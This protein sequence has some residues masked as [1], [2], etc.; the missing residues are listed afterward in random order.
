MSTNQTAPLNRRHTSPAPEEEGAIPDDLPK[1]KTWGVLIAAVV[2]IA[3]FVGLFLVG[4]IPRTARLAELKKESTEMNDMR[5]QVQVARP[6]RSPATISVTLPADTAAWQQTAIFPQANGYLEKQ[7]VD[8]G[9]VV[10][11]GQLLAVISSPDVD[12]QLAQAK[13]NVAQS[14]AN[15]TRTQDNEQLARATLNR[16]EGFFKTGGITQ[17]QLDQFRSA[18]T[19]AQS[20][21]AGAKASVLAA[22]ANVERLSSL[23]AFEKVTAPFAGTITSRNYNLGA[24]M[25]A[26]NTSPGKELFDIANTSVLRVFVDV[27]QM[28]VTSA[29]VGDSAAVE[30][31]NYPGR[32]FAGTITRTSGSVDPSTRKMRYEIDVPNK[33]GLLYPGMYAQAVLKI[34]MSDRSILIPTGALVFDAEGTKVW[35]EQNGVIHARKVTVGRNLGTGIEITRGLSGDENIVTNPGEQLADGAKVDVIATQGAASTS[36]QPLTQP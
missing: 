15:L 24:L 1:V 20:D 12:A 31:R 6:Q 13:A 11:S 22:D 3:A 26:T 23:Q 35:V 16:Y 7:L 34:H 2:V 4:W 33:D 29:K 10:K 32:D 14:H 25:S 18:L 9:D 19:A 36:Q 28:Y 30:V 21:L 5:P 27:D 8:I 17:Q